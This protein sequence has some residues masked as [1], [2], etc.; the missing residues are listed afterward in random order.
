MMTGQ[1]FDN[2]L[3]RP[4]EEEISKLGGHRWKESDGRSYRRGV[5]IFKIHSIKFSN[6]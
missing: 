1:N 4:N 3:E 2:L 6:N 5:K